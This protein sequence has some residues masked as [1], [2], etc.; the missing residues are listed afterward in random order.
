MIPPSDANQAEALLRDSERTQATGK[1][2][3]KQ[4]VLR[5]HPAGQTWAMN[6]FIAKADD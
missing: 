5:C 1:L 3:R 4:L 2:Q 6:N